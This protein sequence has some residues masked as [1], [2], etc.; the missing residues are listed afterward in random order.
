MGMGQTATRHVTEDQ[1]ASAS[2]VAAVTALS[3]SSPLPHPPVAPLSL[4][5]PEAEETSIAT[6]AAA[7]G[8][9]KATSGMA[10]SSACKVSFRESLAKMRWTASSLEALRA[11]EDKLL[12]SGWC[13]ASCCCCCCCV[14]GGRSKACSCCL[15]SLL[16]LL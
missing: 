5:V 15:L 2:P 7:A 12:V 14:V 3:T 10:A 6:A 11:A 4:L 16:Y 1:A 8:D 13:D 9:E